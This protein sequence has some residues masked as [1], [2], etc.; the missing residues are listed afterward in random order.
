MSIQRNSNLDAGALAKEFGSYKRIQ[1]QEVLEDASAE[2][3]YQAMVEKT[4]WMTAYREGGED[5]MVTEDQLRAMGP[6]GIQGLQQRVWQQAQ[7]DFGFMYGCYPLMDEALKA[8]NP[9][10][11]LYKWVDFI[12]SEPFL[13]F[14]R[15]VTGQ[16]NLVRADAQATWYRKGQFL[17]LHNDFD[18]SDDGKRVA[19]VMNLARQWQPDWGGVLQFYDDNNNIA[20][21]FS[22]RFNALSMFQTPQNHAVSYVT[23]FCGNRRLAITGWFRDK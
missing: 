5:K 16:P 19:Y 14:I 7:G 12:N 2:A 17:T 13:A 6:Q 3:L 10:L 4:P 9:D 18:P 1:I 20:Q 8:Q 21:G 23:P 11:L 22:P 15:E